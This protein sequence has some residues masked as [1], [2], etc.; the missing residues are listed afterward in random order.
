VPAVQQTANTSGLT[1]WNEHIHR[2]GILVGLK[3]D[4]RSTYNEALKFYDCFLTTSGRLVSGG[5]A[6][7]REDFDTHTASGKVRVELS[8]PAGEFV[9]LSEDDLNEAV[10]LGDARVV[11]STTTSDCIVV[12]QYRLD[13]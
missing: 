6:E 9:S 1:L 8:V 13:R 4:N 3:V 10:F 2:K 11:G 7:A 5:A 12:A